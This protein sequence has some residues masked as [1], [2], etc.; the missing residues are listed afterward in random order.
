MPWR[1]PETISARPV[2]I[3]VT[4]FSC[5]SSG[6][7]IDHSGEPPEASMPMIEPLVMVM[8]WRT[9]SMVTASGEA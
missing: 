6:N 3:G 9:L 8:I 4:M 7:G 5:H 2:Q 1:V